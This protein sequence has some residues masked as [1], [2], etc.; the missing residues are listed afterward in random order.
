MPSLTQIDVI[1]SRKS[2]RLNCSEIVSKSF[3]TLLRKT[4]EIMNIAINCCIPYGQDTPGPGARG[5]TPQRRL[6]WPQGPAGHVAF[7]CGSCRQPGGAGRGARMCRAW[8]AWLGPGVKICSNLRV[9]NGLV[10][11]Q[12]GSFWISLDHVGSFWMFRLDDEFLPQFG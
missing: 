7:R 9:L 4:C 10:K 12:S 3:R 11:D 8:L 2:C 1:V 6:R 5:F